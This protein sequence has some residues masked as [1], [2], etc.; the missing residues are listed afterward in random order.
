MADKPTF[1]D[2]DPQAIVDA[3][4]AD[5]QSQTGRVLQAAQAE[6]LFINSIAYVLSLHKSQINEAALQ[7]LV[8]FSTAPVLDRLGDIV[9]VKRLAATASLTTLRFVLVAGH[10]GVVIPAGTR[11]ASLDG[12]FIFQTTE[13]LPVAIGELVAFVTAICNVTGAGGNGF[14]PGTIVELL[15]PQPYISSVGNSTESAGGADDETDEQLRERIMLAP[16]SFSTAG[17]RGAYIFHTKSVNQ[18]IVD[19][20]VTNP[21]PGRVAIYPMVSGGETPPEILADVLEVVSGEKIRPLTDTVEVLSP[22][23]LDYAIAVNLTLYTDATQST[24]VAAVQSKLD[25]YVAKKGAKLGQDIKLSQI[26]A[27]CT[28]VDGVYDVAVVEPVA[29]IIVEPTQVAICGSVTCVVTGL[30]EG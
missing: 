13:A 11:V 20:A 8:A 10:S 1:I 14:I 25:A 7:N 30:N 12:Q 21:L 6:R 17:S 26:I 19:V 15:D 27:Q 9:G 24:V 28:G 16:A 29:D 5:Y 22:T 23:V 4:I 2:S 18:L 3:L